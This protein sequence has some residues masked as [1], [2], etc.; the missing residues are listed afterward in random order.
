V[1]RRRCETEAAGFRALAA[2]AA[3][4]SAAAACSGSGD[5]AN[6]IDRQAPHPVVAFVKHADTARQTVWV[7]DAAGG[8]A[9][10]VGSGRAPVVSPDGRR[11]A[12]AGGCEGDPPGPCTTLFVASTA[13]GAP[14]ELARAEEPVWSPDSAR[15]VARSGDRLVSIEVDTGRRTVLARGAFFGWSIEPSGTRVAYGRGPSTDPL[16]GMDLFIVPVEGGTPRRLTRDGHSG[17]PVWG[18]QTIAF[19]R[20]HR[21]GRAPGWPAYDL[22]TVGPDGGGARL[23][24][25]GTTVGDRYELSEVLGTFPV[26][27]SA[28]GRRL[29]ASHQTEQASTPLALD[30]RTGQT[31]PLWRRRARD[32]LPAGLSADGATVLLEIVPVNPEAQPDVATVPWVRPARATVLIPDAS[33]PSWNQ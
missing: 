30:P 15:V 28:D 17:Y 33:E 6:E 19:T 9:R 20:F 2:L 25:R 5:D 23:V 1:K 3:A 27:W 18:P 21:T 12:F 10:R 22:W 16:R 24:V 31:R 4:V 7:R 26:A 32:V 29:L 11:I 13:G 8:E 14:R